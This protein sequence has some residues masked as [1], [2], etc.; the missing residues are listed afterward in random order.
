MGGE[1]PHTIP[2]G[3]SMGADMADVHRM[4]DMTDG[5]VTRLIVRV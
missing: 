4:E 5:T 3:L 1:A 2:P